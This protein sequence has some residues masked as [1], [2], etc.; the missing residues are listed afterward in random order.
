MPWWRSGLL[1][2][3]ALVLL[4]YNLRPMA[5]MI[6]PV[7]PDL[8][9]DLRMGSVEAGLLTSLPTICFAIFGVAAPAIARRLGTHR[10]ILLAVVLLA[11][12]SITRALVHQSWLFI[13]LS[14]LG[15]AGLAA[16][17]V[18][19]PS[20]V[21]RHFPQRVG[22]VT[23]IYS[24]VLSIGVTLGSI[25]AVPLSGALGGWRPAFLVASIIAVVTIVPWVL[26][27]RYD[28]TAVTEQK[29]K[30]NPISLT[31]VARTK[32]GWALAV[33]F[34]FQSAQ[35]YSI[36][37]WMPSIYMAAGLSKAEAGLML[38]IITGAG[39]PLAFLWPAYMSRNPR[40]LRLQLV[41]SSFGLLGYSAMLIA[42][43]SLPWL[44][45]L[46]MAI[47]TSSFPLILAMFG[48]KSQSSAGTAALSGFG[49]GMGYLLA[50]FG[51]FTMGVVHQLTGGWT[52]PLFLL[53]AMSL[54]MSVAGIT[55][56]T[57]GHIE[58]ELPRR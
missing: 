24:L 35:A 22:L 57:R 25:S 58:D 10:L 8:Q 32:L 48:L 56:I 7:L 23:A 45:A 11:V 26:A 28:K 9:R 44:W 52:A 17:N 30:S 3:V 50:L 38:G 54:V 41:I 2:L 51:P 39:I 55:A 13:A 53:L 4:S 46:F 12:G 40:P 43:A 34:G 49:Q 6:G 33:F 21:R 14:A 20:I 36:F 31:A 29:K 27:L 15:L 5:T 1:I 16:G 18:M 37:G 42:P 47:G 19:A